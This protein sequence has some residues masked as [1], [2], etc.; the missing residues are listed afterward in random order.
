MMLTA[1][2]APGGGAG[3]TVK[4]GAVYPLSG[5]TA[6]TGEDLKQGVELALDI[7]NNQYDDLYLPM[8]KETGVLGG[9]KLEVVFADHEGKPDKGKAEAERLITQEKVVAL[10]GSYH[11][12][13]T[14]TASQAAEQAG[15]PFV[16]AESTNAQLTD[17]GFKWF[18]RTTPHD[19]TFA[20]NAFQFMKDLNEQKDAGL[21]TVALVYENTDFGKGFANLAKGFAPQYGFDIVEEVSYPAKTQSVSA[22]VQKLKAANPDAVIFISYVSDAILYMNTMKELGFTPKLVWANDAGFIASGFLENLGKDG[23]YITSR[24]VWAADLA[25]ARPLVDQVNKLYFEK[26]NE[27]MNGNSARAFTGMLVLADAINRAGSTD[28]E[29]IREALKVTNIPGDQLIVPWQGIQFDDNGQNKLGS[30]IVV[31]VLNGTYT[32]VWP[33]DLKAADIVFPFPAWDAR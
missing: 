8:A 10:F 1:C 22:E 17:R 20:E 12:S 26:Y 4:V 18:F 11:S 31:Q 21:K 15:I 29:K 23:E 19:G 5:A 7:V 33:F 2:T 32:T 28:P 27:D 14:K 13:V 6:S 24:E 25:K 30:G 9:K 3:D 16:N